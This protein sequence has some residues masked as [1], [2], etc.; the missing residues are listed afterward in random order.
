MIERVQPIAFV[1]EAKRFSK[2]PE[3]EIIA[4]K[5]DYTCPRLAVDVP[6]FRKGQL[7]ETQIFP[8]RKRVYFLTDKSA[9]ERRV[10]LFAEHFGIAAGN[11]DPVLGVGKP[12]DKFFPSVY[13]LDLI[14]KK[15]GLSVEQLTVTV[16]DCVQ[17]GRRNSCE[18]FVL[19]I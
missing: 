7:V 9:P 14:Q 1:F 16:E 10:D 18:T 19:K 17:I 12:P 4:E 2:S 15:Q 5:A 6:I 11:K 8:E 13:V 3:L